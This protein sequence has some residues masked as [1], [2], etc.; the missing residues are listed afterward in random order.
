MT[1]QTI[2]CP[3]L[4]EYSEAISSPVKFR[5]SVEIQTFE[6]VQLDLFHS[7]WDEIHAKENPTTEWFASWCSRV[8]NFSG[9]GCGDFLHDYCIANPPRFD[10]WPS[11]SWELHNAVN[12]KVGRR[13]FSWAG[14]L[15]RYPR[16]Q[17]PI[18]EQIAVRE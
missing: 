12:V 8:P 15:S 7:L 16:Q 17:S 18:N 13:L 14:F 4:S 3:D 1:R 2:L 9:C 11:W 10:D 5:E 6:Q